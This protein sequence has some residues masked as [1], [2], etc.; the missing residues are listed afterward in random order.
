MRSSLMQHGAHLICLII[1]II[2]LIGK[3]VNLIGNW[4]TK[5]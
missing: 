3:K 5:S 1:A 2:I 4:S